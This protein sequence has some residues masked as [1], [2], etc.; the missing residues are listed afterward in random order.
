MSLFT[1]ELEQPRAN[2]S[3]HHCSDVPY[4]HCLQEIFPTETFLDL[5]KDGRLNMDQKLFVTAIFDPF[6][7]APSNKGAPPL[8]SD[9]L[10]QLVASNRGDPPSPS[11]P[12]VPPAGSTS[13][14][15]PS[16]SDPVV[17]LAGSNTGDP[18]SVVHPAA[19]NN[20][21]PPS[22]VQPAASN[23]GDPP[24]PSDPVVPP[25]GSNSNDI[26]PDSPPP[27]KR[28]GSDPPPHV[29][30]KRMAQKTV[31]NKAPKPQAS[32]RTVGGTNAATKEN[33]NVG[34]SKG[35]QAQ[36]SPSRTTSVEPSP[37]TQASARTVDGANAALEE[38]ANVGLSKGQ[39][40]QKSPSRTTSVEPS[41][42]TQASARTVD[43]A[44][45][46]L[47]ENANDG[48]SK[49][50]QA[51]KNPR[52]TAVKPAVGLKAVNPTKY[53]AKLSQRKKAPA[54]AGHTTRSA[55]SGT[56]RKGDQLHHSVTARRPDSETESSDAYVE[57]PPKQNTRK[58]RKTRSKSTAAQ[59][60][61]GKTSTFARRP[62]SETESSDAYVESPPIQ[63][64]RKKRKTRSK[65][66]AAQ[67][68][69]GKTSAVARLPDSETE[70]SDAYVESRPTQNTRKKRK[71]RSKSSAAQNTRGKTSTDAGRET[72]KGGD[73]KRGCSRPT[74]LRQQMDTQVRNSFGAAIVDM[75]RAQYSCT[76]HF[77]GDS[78]DEKTEG[79][80]DSI[81]AER[82]WPRVIVGTFVYTE[83]G[84]NPNGGSNCKH[85]NKPQFHFCAGSVDNAN[86]LVA[87]LDAKRTTIRAWAHHDALMEQVFHHPSNGQYKSKKS[88]RR[89][90]L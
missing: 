57:S 47:E 85:L 28:R 79:K 35:Q 40:A 7:L 63:N 88:K 39:Q 5:V 37:K 26:C 70:S 36:K 87:A 24:S 25:A 60:T 84:P 30:Q 62:D 21:D 83:Q 54:A 32:A 48:L 72:I 1:Q 27:L 13:G 8:R 53:V 69:R 22:V 10:A 42:K 52:T 9:P 74:S 38:N 45:A 43:G 3:F 4:L 58:K 6:P 82:T 81:A 34:L 75:E 49:G 14:D 90:L 51:Q 71:T 29:Q 59:N 18:P 23:S 77:F 19:S 55:A 67:N 73:R 44:N 65:S 56:K 64:T 2:F 89:L 61:R 80:L 68:T 46:A 50:Q 15:P 31:T 11:D 17:Q 86:H 78:Y 12:V 66:S 41:P 33:A 76:P 16:P 20:G